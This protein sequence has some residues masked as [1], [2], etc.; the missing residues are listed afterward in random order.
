MVLI[1]CLDQKNGMR[2][3]NRR[4]S[5]D[6]EIIH[7]IYQTLLDAPLYIHPDS[8]SLFKD[9]PGKLVV[10]KDFLNN[11]SMFCFV[12][13]ADFDDENID[14]IIIYRF[15]KVYPADEYF[16]IQLDEYVL[17]DETE[18]K[19]YSHDLIAKEVYSRII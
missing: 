1:T 7:D 4:Q 11:T 19:G 18:F 12:E 16:P 17:M 15:D 3:N 13:K 14:E 5:R 6:R 8:E 10:E 2:F 9:Y